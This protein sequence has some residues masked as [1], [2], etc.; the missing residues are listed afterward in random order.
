MYARLGRITRGLWTPNLQSQFVDFTIHPDSDIR[1]YREETGDAEEA[2]DKDEDTFH[3]SDGSIES[4]GLSE[5]SLVCHNGSC[6]EGAGRVPGRDKEKMRAADDLLGIDDP[7]METDNHGSLGENGDNE[8][9]QRD[10]RRHRWGLV[11]PSDALGNFSLPQDQ[12]FAVGARLMASSSQ[13]RTFPAS[14]SLPQLRKAANNKYPKNT[15]SPGTGDTSQT[16][17]YQSSSMATK[18]LT[19]L[20]PLPS[21]YPS[22]ET[23]L[24]TQAGPSTPSAQASDSGRTQGGAAQESLPPADQLPFCLGIDHI[25]DPFTSTPEPQEEL[26]S[27]S[28]NTN[29]GVACYATLPSNG[30]TQPTHKLD[31]LDDSFT[32]TPEQE[33]VPQQ[34]VQSLFPFVRE[35]DTL[36]YPFSS[37]PTS[38]EENRQVSNTTP[39]QPQLNGKQT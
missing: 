18:K 39:A 37:T 19:P 36:R 21:L 30:D 1:G 11:L 12:D 24:D 8:E 13:G 35:L 4:D 32:R 31:N 16:G 17:V 20:P 15:R 2:D 10:I 9:A 34:E 6:H 14:L 25:E 3:K 22:H 29:Q 38:P 23:H 33:A 27:Q 5:A 7:D 28:G 26:S